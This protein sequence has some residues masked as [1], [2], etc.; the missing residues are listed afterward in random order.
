MTAGNMSNLATP[1]MATG[2]LSPW[3]LI[4]TIGTIVT[5]SL[6]FKLVWSMLRY[7]KVMQW[8]QWRLGRQMRAQGHTGP[9][10][11]VFRSNL[12]EMKEL[13]M[14]S[15]KDPLY[16]NGE[17]SHDLM[18]LVYPALNTWKNRYGD[19]FIFTNDTTSRIT[20]YSDD[21]QAVKEIF[22]GNF[23]QY[24][25]PKLSNSPELFGSNGLVFSEHEEWARQR[26]IVRPAFYPGRC[27]KIVEEMATWIELWLQ[28]LENSAVHKEGSDSF[29]IE[30]YA[31]IDD[32]TKDI[33]ARSSFGS[34]FEKGK[35]G[36]NHQV[37]H[38]YLL[39][40][41]QMIPN[42]LLRWIGGPSALQRAIRNEKEE[43]L[44]C[45]REI[46]QER[47]KSIEPGNVES[48]G[49][50]L[51][52]VLLADRDQRLAEKGRPPGEFETEDE[53]LTDQCRTFFLAGAETI[54]SALGWST[55]LMAHYIDWQER[56]RAEVQEVFGDTP[57]NGD[58]L[59]KLKQLDMFV[60][61][62]LRLYTP[63]PT[64]YREVVEPNTTVQGEVLPKYLAIMI[65]FLGV[66][67]SKEYWGEDALQFK[68]ERFANGILEACKQQYAFY[69]FGFG[70]RTCVAQAMAVTEVKLVMAM[71]VQRF[72]FQLSP[73][74]QHEPGLRVVL[75]PKFGIPIIMKRI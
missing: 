45:L 29:E 14:N 62:C 36:F 66:H 65:S 10:F 17:L 8:R 71:L 19:K 34:S 51:L 31:A 59:V 35:K 27:K 40:R 48:Y 32:L 24:E 67:H 68:P 26:K 18:P 16:K 47:R 46:I 52:G 15:P 12:K 41:Q 55:V 3:V 60:H 44:K 6:S 70:P 42:P 38:M 25:K 28:K 5:M 21:A 50:D 2:R 30:M 64:T 69:P 63:A 7:L 9:S 49:G 56:I 57:P 1:S 73:S 53:H 4:A 20:M 39:Y 11:G 72:S 54:H 23:L 74:Y 61:E 13:T 43:L 22:A 58:K 37:K 33:L 75:Y